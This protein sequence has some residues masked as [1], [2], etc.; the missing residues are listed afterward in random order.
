[1]NREKQEAYIKRMKEETKKYDHEGT[2]DIQKMFAK[3]V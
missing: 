3:N 1:M 2:I